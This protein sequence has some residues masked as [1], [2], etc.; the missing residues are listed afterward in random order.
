MAAGEKSLLLLTALAGVGPVYALYR[1][2]LWADRG[3]TDKQPPQ[4][5]AQPFQQS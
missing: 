5:S 2:V 4:L 1:P 3:S